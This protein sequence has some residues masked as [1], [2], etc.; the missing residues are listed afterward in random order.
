MLCREVRRMVNILLCCTGSVA[1]IKLQELLEQLR[2]VEGCEVKVKIV[3]TKHSQHFLPELTSL[4]VPGDTVLTDEDEWRC[5]EGRGDPVLHIE[6]RRWADLCLIAPLSANTLAKL[7][8]GL[9]DN[10]LTSTLRAWDLTRPV[11][12]APAMNTFMWE[13][14]V[15]SQQL[16]LLSQWGYTVIPPVVKTLG[17]STPPL[18]LLVSLP[19]CVCFQCAVTRAMVRWLVL[20]Q[21]YKLSDPHS[22]FSSSSFNIKFQI[23]IDDV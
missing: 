13:H 6:L 16:S 7:S 23:L 8:H 3:L 12:V 20:I 17:S 11:L 2:Q 9:A 14:P 19:H 1:T 5:W 4:G 22:I 15:T 21:L 10:L 18:L